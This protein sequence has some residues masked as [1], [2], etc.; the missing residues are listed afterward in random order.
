MQ[1]HFDMNYSSRR[2]HT[3]ASPPHT[4]TYVYTHTAEFLQEHRHV[5]E[6]RLDPII[7]EIADTRARSRDEL[8]GKLQCHS[9]AVPACLYVIY[10][11]ITC[12]TVQEGSVICS[13]TLWSRITY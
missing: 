4:H 10:K 7:R 2:K 5:L 8:E 3:H 6:A 9:A 12:R 1:V 13:A 11:Y